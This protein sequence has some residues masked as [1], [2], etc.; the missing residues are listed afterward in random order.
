MAR[1]PSGL[2]HPTAVYAKKVV[3]GAWQQWCCPD[4]IAACRRHLEDLK[5]QGSPDFPY[6]FDTTRADRV[7]RFFR[8]SVQ[9]RGVFQ[10]QPIE[11]Q[12]WQEFDL[13]CVYGW[14]HK[15][16]GFRRFNRVF[17]KRGRGNVKSTANAVKGL[18]HMTADCYYPPYRPEEAVFELTP[19]VD[20]VAADKDQAKIVLK[21]ARAIALATPALRKR[22]HVP[23]ANP[24]THRT[25]GG[26]MRA[27]SAETQ[28]KD[29]LSPSYYCVDEYEAHV[30]SDL[31]DLGFNAM[32]KRPQALLDCIL[33]A[34]DGADSRPAKT[35]EDYA[36][37]VVRGQVQDDRYFVMIREVPDT[38]YP[39]DKSK[40][41]W[42]NPVLRWPNAYAEILLAQID[43]EYTAAYGAEDPAKI[44]KFLTRRLCQWQAAS[45]DSYLSEA[46]LRQAKEAQIPSDAFLDLTRGLNAWAG[47]DLG[48]RIDLTGTGMV[49]PL[50]DGRYAITAH[51]FMPEEG[52]ARHE[53][54]DHVPYLSWAKQG[55]CTLTPGAV[56]DNSYAYDWIC[57]VEARCELELQEVDY[58]GHNATDLAIAIC[59]DRKDEDFCVEIRQTCAGQ[60]LAVKTFRELLMQGKLVFEYNPLLMWC[61]GNAIV[62]ENYY[63]DIKLSKAHKDDTHRIDP[64]A[65]V[66]N[67]MARALLREE[68][69]DLSDAAAD[70]GYS[71]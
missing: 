30:V 37:K 7:Y 6:V 43:S 12:P 57:G 62:H 45:E 39:H 52:A 2:H 16:T 31:Y 9:V 66:M 28:N 47:F 24:I 8:Q 17:D 50:P 35:E 51:G 42:S 49:I 3:S 10:G 32:G 69:S 68:V 1:R 54:T 70:E 64:L 23:K 38:E 59:N 41:L 55:Y 11:L 5:R 19:E 14:V 4:E 56:T 34:G 58:D 36:R 67:A 60:T 44:R 46:L 15:D 65:A 48:K 13:G 33:T 18:Y 63:G 29:G 22:L 20:C 40:W 27:L 21:D 61:L 53:R 71:M 25:R 26:E